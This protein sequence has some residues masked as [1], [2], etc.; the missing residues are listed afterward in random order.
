MIHA[1]NSIWRH[2]ENARARGGHRRRKPGDVA[3]EC[4]EQRLAL[5]LSHTVAPFAE[6]PQTF[7]AV[8]VAPYQRHAEVAV[9]T[10]AGDALTGKGVPGEDVVAN[11]A[12]EQQSFT[13]R[14]PTVTDVDRRT[15][16][17]M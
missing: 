3:L 14:H 2:C 10:A 6:T 13:H 8:G 9:A 5:S 1:W 4:L 17:V 16:T 15:I 11:T 7:A 12:L